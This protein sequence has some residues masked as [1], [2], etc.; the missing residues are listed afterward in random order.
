[1]FAK[2]TDVGCDGS[3]GPEASSH[4][5]DDMTFAFSDRLRAEGSRPT[6]S[7]VHTQ[8]EKETEGRLGGDK[9]IG[10]QN[11]RNQ[12]GKIDA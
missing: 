8:A 2:R 12:G 4:R 1:M 11:G 6:T 3:V 7:L 10:R 5:H 9:R